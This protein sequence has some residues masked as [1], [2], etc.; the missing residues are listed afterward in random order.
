M[1][2]LVQS[3]SILPLNPFPGGTKGFCPEQQHAVS[4]SGGGLELG[5]GVPVPDIEAMAI[6]RDGGSTDGSEPD[7][8]CALG[9]LSGA[10]RRADLLVSTSQF[11]GVQ[12]ERQ[13]KVIGKKG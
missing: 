12:N 13:V 2:S 3:T 1:E 9:G 6:T 8:G 7:D 5:I 4:S 10:T 11:V